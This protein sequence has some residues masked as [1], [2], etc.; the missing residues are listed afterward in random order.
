[1]LESRA[2]VIER[3]GEAALIEVLEQ[4]GCGA[5]AT[6]EACGTTLLARWLPR[7]PRRFEVANPIQAGPGDEVIVAVEE[8]KLARSAVAVFAR[9]LGLVLIGAVTGALAGGGDAMAAAG[10]AAGLAGAY[11]LVRRSGRAR[12]HAGQAPRIVRA[13]RAPSP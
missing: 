3:R 11:V 4:A 9:A 2:R 10:A 1:M 7:R 8:G 5:C 6:G 13:V 12:A